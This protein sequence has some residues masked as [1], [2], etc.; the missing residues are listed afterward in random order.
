MTQRKNSKHINLSIY[1]L[2][3]HEIVNNLNG[4]TLLKSAELIYSVSCYLSAISSG[5]GTSRH[6]SA[7]V[8]TDRH[9]ADRDRHKI[10]RDE[11]Y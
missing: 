11:F 7:P 1:H 3:T 5:I 9:R 2:F 6:R 10:A 4:Y 8:D